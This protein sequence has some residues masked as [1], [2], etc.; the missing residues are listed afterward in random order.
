[1]AFMKPVNFASVLLIAAALGLWAVQHSLP[2]A[3]AA[4]ALARTMAR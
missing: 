4:S 3:K 2:S 1:M